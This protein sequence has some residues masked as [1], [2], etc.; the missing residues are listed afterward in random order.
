MLPPAGTL[1]PH[2]EMIDSCDGGTGFTVRTAAV[3]VAIPFELL[4]T[5]V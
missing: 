2:V 5:T 4:T 1:W 3:L